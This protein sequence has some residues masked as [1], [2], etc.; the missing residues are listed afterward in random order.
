M[1]QVSAKVAG[2]SLQIVSNVSTVGDVKRKLG[3]EKHTASVNGEP[4]DDSQTLNDDEF[5]T[6]APSVKGA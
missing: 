2:G 3:A 4:A 1:A 6:L 5:V